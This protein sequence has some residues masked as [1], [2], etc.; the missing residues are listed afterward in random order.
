[1]QSEIAKSPKR[2]YAESR[3]V[4]RSSKFGGR[5]CAVKRRRCACQLRCCASLA[6][7]GIHRQ[8]RQQFVNKNKN[9]SSDSSLSC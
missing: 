7:I 5:R 9:S 3:N 1:M 6:K 2:H 4:Q 8:N